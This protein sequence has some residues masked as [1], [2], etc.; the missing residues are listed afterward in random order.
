MTDYSELDRLIIESISNGR[1]TFMA[2]DSREVY[3][4]TQRLAAETGR[5]AFRIID[6]RLQALRKK[7]VIRY[8]T[9]DKWTVV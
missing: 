8:T 4:E 7:G 5:T 1:N 2:I 6:G 3:T 9:A